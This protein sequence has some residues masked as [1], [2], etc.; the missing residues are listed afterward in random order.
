M[1]IIFILHWVWMTFE[2]LII[3]SPNWQ[4]LQTLP[5]VTQV[6]HLSHNSIITFKKGDQ[7]PRCVFD[8]MAWKTVKGESVKLYPIV[9][10]MFHLSTQAYAL[11]CWT[12][13]F[14][15]PW[16]QCI[17]SHVI[18]HKLHV[19]TLF[20]TTWIVSNLYKVQTVHHPL[21]TS[22]DFSVFTVRPLITRPIST[23]SQLH[24]CMS[25]AVINAV[26]YV[27]SLATAHAFDCYIL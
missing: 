15:L 13:N 9:H 7:I 24:Q 21:H 26:T 3:R 2:Y 18:H 22:T 14:I 12:H 23:Q 10:S 19:D 6:T 17:F 16:A 4:N 11:E 20:L 8:G 27:F 25:L 1:K 5:K